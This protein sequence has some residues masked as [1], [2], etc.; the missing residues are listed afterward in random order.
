VLQIRGD[1]D[2][3]QE[4]LRAKRLRELRLEHLEGDMPVVPQIL[5]E[6]DGGHATFAERPLEAVAAGE[7]VI[8][9]IKLCGRF[10]HTLFRRL[11][12][13]RTYMSAV[14]YGQSDVLL[15]RGA[16]AAMKAPAGTRSERR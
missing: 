3:L 10:D 4:A 1:L 16:A 8:Q 5:C 12:H 15:R 7:C 9:A 11:A 2:F 13:H 6:I 14:A